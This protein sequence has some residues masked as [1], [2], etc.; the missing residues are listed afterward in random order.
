MKHK[1]L[2]RNLSKLLGVYFCITGV[3]TFLQTLANGLLFQMSTK[4]Y[5]IWTALSIAAP[6]F[7]VIAGVFL[8]RGSGIVAGWAVPGNRPYCPECGYDLT[9]SA[10]QLC[11]E[12]GTD[13][14]SGTQ[15]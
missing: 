15:G 9:G 3:T 13:P 8:F 2:F 14:R 1:T 7:E 11:P 5:W 12:C 10:S 4:S 6:L